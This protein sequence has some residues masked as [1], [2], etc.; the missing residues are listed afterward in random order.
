MT[1]EQK[2]AILKK[3]YEESNKALVKI[4]VVAFVFWGIPWLLE[5]VG[6]KRK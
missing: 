5:K 2:E 6:R 3:E 4:A 1:P